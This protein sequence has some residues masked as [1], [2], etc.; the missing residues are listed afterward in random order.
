MAGTYGGGASVVDGEGAVAVVD[1]AQNLFRVSAVA[2][3][4]ADQSV[5]FVAP[6]QVIDRQNWP[7]PVFR[8]NAVVC[9]RRSLRGRGAW[10]E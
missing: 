9:P 5:G 1:A 6:L 2:R 7:P 4:L 8:L 10:G 3:G